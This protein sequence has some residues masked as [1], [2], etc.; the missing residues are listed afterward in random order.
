MVEGTVVDVVGAVVEL[1][2]VAKCVVVV[3]LG[4]ATGYVLPGSARQTTTVRNPNAA[5]EILL[6]VFAVSLLCSMICLPCN[7]FPLTDHLMKMNRCWRLP[8]YIS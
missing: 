2:D 5:M 7:F 3:L 1:G 8:C 6:M 4:D